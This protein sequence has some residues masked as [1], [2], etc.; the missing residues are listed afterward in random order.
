[1]KYDDL[2]NLQSEIVMAIDKANREQNEDVLIDLKKKFH[3][4]KIDMLNAIQ[5]E[6]TTRN[7]ISAKD[8]KQMVMMNPVP[9]RY[10]TGI[11]ILDEHLKGGFEVG[12]FVQ[13]AGQSGGGKTTILLNILA[14]ISRGKK[15]MMFNFEMGSRRIINRLDKMLKEPSQWENLMVDGLTRNIDALCDEITL[16]ARDGI[17]FFMIDSMMKIETGDADELKSQAMV[18][19]RLSKVAQEREVIIILIN[20]MSEDAIKSKRFS[21]K[22]S[23]SQQYD[24]DMSL[25]LVVQDEKRRLFCSKNRQDEYL[26]NFEIGLND[27]SKYA[28][29][30][31]EITYEM[32]VQ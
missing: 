1:M 29:P 5:Q 10:E 23:N 27:L 30:E 9:P 25:F 7:A 21:L 4:N 18:S 17:K 32:A 8:L 26:F 14:N 16:S 28:K 19:N 22:G 15:C 20:Q 24:S 3:Q 12:T 31:L 6:D 13:L 11:S 2:K